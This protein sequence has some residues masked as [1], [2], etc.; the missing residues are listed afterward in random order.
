MRSRPLTLAI[1]LSNG[2]WSDINFSLTLYFGVQTDERNPTFLF[3]F[4][5][6]ASTIGSTRQ[7]AVQWFQLSIGRGPA[8]W[9]SSSC[10]SSDTSPILSGYWSQLVQ[11]ALQENAPGFWFRFCWKMSVSKSTCMLTWQVFQ[12]LSSISFDSCIK[13]FHMPA[14]SPWAVK[15]INWKSQSC[16]PLVIS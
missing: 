12:G 10:I 7:H 11:W 2:G 13:L 15:Q 1:E 5:N 6:L 4:P 3:W 16:I 9:H 8:S 14:F